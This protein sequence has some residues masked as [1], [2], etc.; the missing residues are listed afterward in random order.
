MSDLDNIDVVH[1]LRE[2]FEQT[3]DCFY[4]N[5]AIGLTEEMMSANS[6]ADGVTV[7]T[8]LLNSLLVMRA[9]VRKSRP[10][11]SRPRKY[12]V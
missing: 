9:R 8:P 3:G 1:M 7:L 6:A 4:L 5:H 11:G 12:N 10:V 2:T